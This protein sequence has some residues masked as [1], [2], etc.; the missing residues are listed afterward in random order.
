LISTIEVGEKKDAEGRMEKD[1]G[2]WVTVDNWRTKRVG[3]GVTTT[4]RVVC[5]GG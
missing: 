3:S 2:V 5:R 4:G 1:I